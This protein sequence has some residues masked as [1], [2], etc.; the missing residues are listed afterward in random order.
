LFEHL[1]LYDIILLL[2]IGYRLLSVSLK[3]NDYIK[4]LVKQGGAVF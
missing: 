4:M 3:F 2:K 1:F